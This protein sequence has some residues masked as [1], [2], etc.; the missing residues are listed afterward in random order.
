MSEQYTLESVRATA[1]GKELPIEEL[2]R[3]HA[4]FEEERMI[5]TRYGQTLTYFYAPAKEGTYPLVIHLHGGGFVKGHRD[6]DTVFCRNLVQNAAVAVVDVDYHTAPEQKYPYALHE[7]F[8][9]AN[10]IAQNPEEFL[11]DPEKI[12]WS[13]HSAGGN[14]VFGME[15]LA[16]QEGTAKPALLISDY[17]PLDFTQDPGEARYAYAPFNR[18]P[19]EKARKY[20]EWYIDKQYVREITASPVFA[21]KE[22]L[23][24]FP[25]VLLIMADEDTLTEGSIRFAAK[26]MDAGVTVT[27]KRVKGSAHG[28]T[29]QRKKGFEVGEKLI[30]EALEKVKNGTL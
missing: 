23:E 27:A 30:F 3:F 16:Q 2:E 19:V 22:E 13:G 26:L 18:V 24:P 4:G 17:P 12:V 10:Y 21:M 25:P 6:Q 8:D 29:V 15:F 20:N 14:L 28:F 9:I 5:P 7:C 1:V 11:A